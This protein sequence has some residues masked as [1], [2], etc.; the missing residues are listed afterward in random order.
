MNKTFKTLLRSVAGTGS[1][2]EPIVKTCSICYVQ[3]VKEFNPKAA[4]GDVDRSNAT[5]AAQSG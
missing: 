2:S 4:N 3:L 1:V 5:A